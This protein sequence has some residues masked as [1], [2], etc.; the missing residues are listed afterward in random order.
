M[1]HAFGGDGSPRRATVKPRKDRKSAVLLG[2]G[3]DGRDGHVRITRGENF[4][5]LGGS[6]ET[7]QAMQEKCIR[8]NEKL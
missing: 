3:L 1:I 4:H 8:F 6:P 7:H 5:L 2:I